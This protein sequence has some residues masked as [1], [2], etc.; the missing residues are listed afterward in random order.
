MLV[1]EESCK[2]SYTDL[3][4]SIDPECTYLHVYEHTKCGH[5]HKYVQIVLVHISKVD[6][7]VLMVS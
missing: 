6:I 3:T 2:A 1:Y 7:C 5:K 4:F